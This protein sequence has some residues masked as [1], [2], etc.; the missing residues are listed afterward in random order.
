ML[1][2]PPD[3]VGRKLDGMADSV[4]PDKGCKV[5]DGDLI[6]EYWDES[7]SD[8]FPDNDDVHILP[9]G[10]GGHYKLL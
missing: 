2:I 10:W 8:N 4:L 9:N 1:M 5:L 3:G 6:H 7:D